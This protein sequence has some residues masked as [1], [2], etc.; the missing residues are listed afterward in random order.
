MRPASVGR[1]TVLLGLSA[2]VGVVDAF[3]AGGTM[4]MPDT[5][6]TIAFDGALRRDLRRRLR[7]IRWS[8][9]VT[10]DWRHVDHRRA[11]P[12]DVGA[13]PS[14]RTGATAPT[15]GSSRR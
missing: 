10:A 14:P 5:P 4:T 11:V 9:A 3:G 15:R 2:L 12:H 7:G 6:F 8:D 1:R 13:T